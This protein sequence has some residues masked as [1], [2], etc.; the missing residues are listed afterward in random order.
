MSVGLSREGLFDLREAA[1]LFQFR[2]SLYALCPPTKS[3]AEL[4][5]KIPVEKEA[6]NPGIHSPVSEGTSCDSLSPEV[7]DHQHCVRHKHIGIRGVLRNFFR[8]GGG[9]PF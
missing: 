1:D 6:G 4:N 2:D 7:R 5:V 3:Q 9:G 8:G